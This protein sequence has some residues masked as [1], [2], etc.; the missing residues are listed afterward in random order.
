LT[1][2][3][4][5][6]SQLDADGYFAGMTLADESPLEPGVFLLP[7]GA[8]DSPAP[9]PV[10]GMRAKWNGEAWAYEPVPAEPEPEPEPKQDPDRLFIG[11]TQ[12][13]LDRF[14]G[15][16]GY[17]G[18]LSACTYVTSTVPKFAAEAQYCVEARDATWVAAYEMLD[19]VKAGTLSP[20]DA[21]AALPA[22]QWPE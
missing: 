13:R 1:V 17:E 11:A 2:Q 15:T 9:A 10:E 21:L 7:G 5:Q 6:V 8:V 16:R 12:E 4:K 18:I 20:E 19:E 3:T 14:A 22:L